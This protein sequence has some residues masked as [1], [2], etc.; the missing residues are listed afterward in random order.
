MLQTILWRH[1]EKLTSTSKKLTLSPMWKPLIWSHLYAEFIQSCGITSHILRHHWHLFPHQESVSIDYLKQATCVMLKFWCH[2]WVLPQNARH[3]ENWS[4]IWS[5]AWTSK[6]R[7]FWSTVSPDTTFDR[8]W[9]NDKATLIVGAPCLQ[10]T[11]VAGIYFPI[12][13]ATGMVNLFWVQLH[14]LKAKSFVA[15]SEMFG[16]RELHLL[17]THAVI[18]YLFCALW[19]AWSTSLAYCVFWMSLLVRDNKTEHETNFDTRAA[20]KWDNLY[21]QEHKTGQPSKVT[22]LHF[23]NSQLDTTHSRFKA[24]AGHHCFVPCFRWGTNAHIPVWLTD[25]F[26]SSWSSCA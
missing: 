16:G 21:Q 1:Q 8:F 22:H 6:V 10:K 24:T 23:E 18:L 26:H 11:E 5:R 20:E 12:W 7:R 25:C 15:I 4:S 17:C 14:F 19:K 13:Q 3:K 9:Q 2:P